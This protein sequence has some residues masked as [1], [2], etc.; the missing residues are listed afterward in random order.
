[1]CGLFF[2]AKSATDSTAV[3]QYCVVGEREGLDRFCLIPPHTLGN[4]RD[5]GEIESAQDVQFQVA[6][7]LP[8]PGGETG[9]RIGQQRTHAT[10][11]R[12]SELGDSGTAAK[13][14]PGP[15]A[16]RSTAWGPAA[17]SRVAA[18][19]EPL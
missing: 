3:D 16:H 6:A 18:A 12:R 11:Q 8:P 17:S 4:K 1:M 7:L 2:T 14:V 5:E 13:G 19:S 10:L 9:Q 15:L